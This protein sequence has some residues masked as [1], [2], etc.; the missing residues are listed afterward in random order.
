M[1]GKLIEVHINGYTY[2]VDEAAERLHVQNTRDS[3][4]TTFRHLTMN[5]QRQLRDYIQYTPFISGED[6][7]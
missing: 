1:S 6:E 5:E 3:S 4:F 7:Q 2:F